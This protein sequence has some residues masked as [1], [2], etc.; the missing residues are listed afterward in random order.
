MKKIIIM[1]LTLV[2]AVFA[3][4]EWE[5]YES[6]LS[7]AKEENK[8]ILI[9]FSAPTCKVCNYMKTKVYTDD[10]VQEYMD[11]HFV[12]VEIDSDE[13]P[14]PKKFQLLGTPNYFFLNSKEEFIVP[15]MLGGAKKE[16]FLEKL[17]SVTKTFKAH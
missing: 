11:E 2:S 8:A 14:N 1:F 9:M 10:N 5:D 16:D 17:K 6:A 4:I 3:E 15:R 12:S 7:L 13:N